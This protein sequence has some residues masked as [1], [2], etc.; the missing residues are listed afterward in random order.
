MLTSP[1]VVLLA[2]GGVARLR[3][4]RAAPAV[5]VG[6]LLA[7]GVLASDA[8]QYHSTD[9]APTARY[10]ELA[11]IAGRFGRGPTL[12]PDFDEWS[13]YA[14]RHMDVG[15]LNF[16]YRARGLEAI[17]PHHGD[18]V[19]LDQVPDRALVAY[20]VIVTGR[21]PLASRPPSAYRLLWQG[22]YYEVWGRRPGA[23]PALAH[24]GLS[25]AHPAPCVG[26]GLLAGLARAHRARLVAAVA[27]EAVPLDVTAAAPPDWRRPTLPDL[28]VVIRGR[29]HLQA[30]FTVLRAGVWNVWIRGEIMP[31]VAVGVDGRQAASVRAQLRG[32]VYNPDTLPPIPVRLAAGRHVLTLA[33]ASASL[34][35]GQGGSDTLNAIYLTPAAAGATAALHTVAPSRWRSLC[36]ARLDWVEA[37]L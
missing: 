7:G 3:Q 26:L 20:P 24:L 27:P 36:G 2:W 11:S 12:F 4:S 16:I 29:G 35:P 18:P 19:D 21:D 31:T 34:A 13:L 6:L 9:L 1:L 10:T 14:L 5:V 32:N 15:G 23:P 22:T 28:G 37:T 8:M 25:A 17:A 33:R 30:A